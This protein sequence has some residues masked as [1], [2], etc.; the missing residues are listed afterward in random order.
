MNEHNK[1]YYTPYLA[2]KR[3]GIP[4]KALMQW[5]WLGKIPE[6]YYYQSKNGSVF[7]KKSYIDQL[8]ASIFSYDIRICEKIN[9][10][11]YLTRKEV[12]EF[13]QLSQNELKTL[14]DKNIFKSDECILYCSNYYYFRG[15]IERIIN[16]D[17]EVTADYYTT[18]EVSSILR[19]PEPTLFNW[20][21]IG[22]IPEEDCF[23]HRNRCYYK[24][25]TVHRM[26]K[27]RDMLHEGTENF[28][29][30]Q[31]VCEVFNIAPTTLIY[32]REV[33]RLS[34][35][36][37][38][39]RNGKYFYKA[40][41]I[42]EI[43]GELE[44][45]N[46]NYYKATEA[47]EILQLNIKTLRNWCNRSGIFTSSD[48]IV[49]FGDY[50]YKKDTINKFYEK[51][52]NELVDYFTARELSELY[53][54]DENALFHW[55]NKGLIT[56]HDWKI[57]TLNSTKKYFY[58]P[59][60]HKIFCSQYK[61]KKCTFDIRS[62]TDLP[63]EFRFLLCKSEMLEILPFNMNDFLNIYAK[64]GLI[65]LYEVRIEEDDEYLVDLIYS[66]SNLQQ[67]IE[68]IDKGISHFEASDVMRLTH[69]ATRHIFAKS[70]KF[71]SAMFTHK[72]WV[73]DRKKF[74][75]F[76]SEYKWENVENFV[77]NFSKLTFDEQLRLRISMVPYDNQNEQTVYWFTQFSLIK[78]GNVKG[79]TRQ[80]HSFCLQSTLILRKI[81]RYLSKK[82]IMDLTDEELREIASKEEITD[83]EYASI[84]LF[85]EW[86]R[87]ETLCRYQNPLPKLK[88][89]KNKSEIKELYDPN[90][91]LV[92]FEF[93]MDVERHLLYALNS[94]DYTS[95]W[96]FVGMHMNSEFRGGD[97]VRLPKV[98]L[99]TIEV[100][101]L[102]F[103]LDNRLSAV[104]ASSIIK[105][106]SDF[107]N[108]M[109]FNSNKT[110]SPYIF[111][112]HPEHVYCMATAFVIAELHR[113]QT[114][115]KDD[116]LI[117]T[118][119]NKR[120]REILA[121]EV[122]KELLKS[123]RKQIKNDPD[124]LPSFESVKMN[125]SFIT[126]MYHGNTLKNVHP[127][128]ATMFVKRMRGHK[129]SNTTVNYVLMNHKDGT[130]DQAIMTLFR[131][132]GFGWI[133]DT[134]CQLL[135]NDEL[136]T[137][138]LRTA[139]IS[140]LQNNLSLF[141]LETTAG[142]LLLQ[143]KNEVIINLL[144]KNKV[145][146][147]EFALKLFMGQLPSRKPDCYCYNGK[148]VCSTPTKD[149]YTCKW[150]IPKKNVLT[151]LSLEINLSI[152]RILNE[153]L[154]LIIIKEVNKIIK[155]LILISEA[156]QSLGKEVVN[157]YLDLNE[158]R[159]KLDSIDFS[160]WEKRVNSITNEHLKIMNS[161]KNLYLGGE[162]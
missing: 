74:E 38:E 119:N 141:D 63:T 72:G 94:R 11:F 85:C 151:T 65:Q 110:N 133:F 123:Y 124:T 148:D 24:K 89:Q 153:S 115:D 52:A 37:Y 19:I 126:Y 83:R 57:T 58:R 109:D 45:I 159:A 92:Y 128:L 36:D 108:D 70:N 132:D 113:R 21:K 143:Q 100:Y 82:E 54:F 112:V 30:A 162:L 29:F 101:S 47:S 33:G 78:L 2:A 120:F 111:H 40:S 91:Y 139:E 62:K 129:K 55:I 96:V 98:P 104:Q 44:R 114:I 84:R 14:R 116:L 144:T 161:N 103:F 26:K 106:M 93:M 88:I 90:E 27:E 77:D 31:D 10:K 121:F 66:Y 51:Q 146:I 41:K 140:Q 1:K 25:E 99:E 8:D 80:K 67:I 9:D 4:E 61:V 81:L 136:Q 42:K 157:I 39:I 49:F 5:I 50:Y 86:L 23:I 68:F 35:N 16:K 71:E 6:S 149:C 142:L 18:K 28:I 48:Y 134:L 122:N 95:V 3:I 145:Q 130:L 60:I 43:A 154:E 118:G 79:A 156:I 150:I 125:R 135:T 22:K 64:A 7:L 12:Y 158:L 137:P 20:R 117:R 69:S 107:L 147:R 138:A 46:C 73:V 53:G 155:L 34:S 160:K 56:E 76:L 17:A 152:S 13:Y 102:D 105:Q 127:E 97:I 15:A 32:W 87:E 75:S 131:R 59:K